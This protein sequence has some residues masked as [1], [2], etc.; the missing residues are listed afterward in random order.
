[1]S[2]ADIP[3]MGTESFPTCLSPPQAGEPQPSPSPHLSQALLAERA[4]G[5]VVQ[6]ALQALLAEGVSTWRRHRLKEHPAKEPL[7]LD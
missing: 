2:R 7:S 1:M 5:P 4:V 3:G 6:A